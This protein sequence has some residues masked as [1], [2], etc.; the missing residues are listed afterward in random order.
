MYPFGDGMPDLS[1]RNHHRGPAVHSRSP[2]AIIDPAISAKQRCPIMTSKRED[3]SATFCRPFQFSLRGLFLVATGYAVLWALAALAGPGAMGLLI[4]ASAMAIAAIVYASTFYAIS[5][6]PRP[7]WWRIAA[8]VVVLAGV[9][10]GFWIGAAYRYPVSPTVE[11]CGFPFPAAIFILESGRW[12]DYVGNP[13][14]V[15]GNV[16]IL[17]AVA[18]L[19]VLLGVLLRLFSGSVAGPSPDS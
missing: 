12:I 14:V 16:F 7:K 2:E 17:R 4:I 6:L 9:P 19:P 5:R 1:E 13:L 11:Y 3:R 15:F 10:V 8:V 18:L